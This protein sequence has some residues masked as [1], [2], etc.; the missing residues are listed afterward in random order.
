MNGPAHTTL[1]VSM[2]LLTWSMMATCWRRERE[3][4]CVC[5]PQNKVHHNNNAGRVCSAPHLL[6]CHFYPLTWHVQILST[7]EKSTLIVVAIARNVARILCTNVFSIMKHIS[8]PQRTTLTTLYVPRQC[9]QSIEECLGIRFLRVFHQSS[10]TVDHISCAQLHT[11]IVTPVVM[12]RA[13]WSHDTDPTSCD[14][15]P[16]SCDTDSDVM[17]SRTHLCLVSK[18]CHEGSV[19]QVVQGKSPCW[20]IH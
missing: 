19:R 14:Q 4:V 8:T 13:L 1:C 10:A 12:R 15:D 16:W 3:S 20:F 7:K 6:L 5:V 2:K 9:I 18:L 17:R 11:C